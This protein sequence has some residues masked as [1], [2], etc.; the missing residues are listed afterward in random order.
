MYMLRTYTQR[1]SPITKKKS[2]P[3]TKNLKIII[4]HTSSP[5]KGVSIIGDYDVWLDVEDVVEEFPQQ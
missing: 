2:L 3:P 1:R 5:I 4:T